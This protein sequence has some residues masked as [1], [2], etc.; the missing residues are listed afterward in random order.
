MTKEASSERD[1]SIWPAS[2]LEAFVPTVGGLCFFPN[3]QGPG[4]H[5]HKYPAEYSAPGLRE[6]EHPQGKG[7]HQ[8]GLHQ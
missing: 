3:Q 7:R 4:G 1:T 6:S 5:Y 2:L 8:I